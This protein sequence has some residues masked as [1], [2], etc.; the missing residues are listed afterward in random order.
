MSLIIAGRFDT[1]EKAELASNE[2]KRRGFTAEDLSIF[3]VSPQGQHSRT[4]IGGDATNDRGS[5]A[6]P[7]GASKGVAVGIILGAVVASGIFLAFK[8]PVVVIGIGAAIGAYLGSLAVRCRIRRSRSPDRRRLWIMSKTHVT[9]GYCWR[10][11]QAK[12]RPSPSRRRCAHA[13]RWMSNTRPAYGNKA[14]GPILIRPER[15]CLSPSRNALTI[16]RGQCGE[17]TG[18]T[19]PVLQQ[20]DARG[21]DTSTQSI[22]A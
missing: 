3:Y 10:S 12:K 15:P 5:K 4:P 7:K 11:T 1:F 18:S 22:S 16:K 2:L 9:Q 21:F 13:A 6:A 17:G 14:N 8:A 19:A 20:P